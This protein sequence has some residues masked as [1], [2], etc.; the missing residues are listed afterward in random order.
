M[1]YQIMPNVSE[2]NTLME[3]AGDQPAYGIPEDDGDEFKTSIQRHY[4]YPH[5]D[6]AIC[7]KFYSWLNFWISHVKFN[8]RMYLCITTAQLE[9]FVI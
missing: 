8:I 4:L 6:V 3:I 2:S 9:I 5:L 1:H 7:A